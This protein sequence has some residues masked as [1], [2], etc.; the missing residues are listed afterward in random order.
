LNHSLEDTEQQVVAAT[1]Q[2]VV[3][4]VVH[5]VR[6]AATHGH[7]PSALWEECR[8][9]LTTH[10]KQWQERHATTSQPLTT[11]AAPSSS[12]SPVVALH[13]GLSVLKHVTAHWTAT[14]HQAQKMWVPQRTRGD[15]IVYGRIGRVVLRQ[16]RIFVRT[17]NTTIAHHSSTT[18]PDR[19]ANDAS[20]DS[21]TASTAAALPSSFAALGWNPPILIERVIIRPHEFCPPRTVSDHHPPQWFASSSSKNGESPGL[22]HA[23]PQP[24]LEQSPVVAMHGTTDQDDDEDDMEPFSTV[25]HRQSP[26]P[27]L[28]QPLPLCIDVVI[29][30]VLAEVAKSNTG[31]LFQT[32]LS[33]MADV[34][35]AASQNA[36]AVTSAT[37]TP[38]SH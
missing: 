10:L 34:L 11:A 15:K 27:A 1:A 21:A 31:R 16:A 37:T 2:H 29:Q 35:A 4:Q 36:A 26:M 30:R 8:H 9:S 24:P 3:S 25:H 33:E 7:N 38:Q 12:S 22:D 13:Q 19:N 14:T 17:N 5:A 28:Y 18:L 20:T 6:Q 32:A 23:E